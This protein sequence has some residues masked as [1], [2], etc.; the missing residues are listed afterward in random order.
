MW[1]SVLRVDGAADLII[2]EPEHVGPE[3]TGH[4]P[5]V[6]GLLQLYPTITSPQFHVPTFTSKGDPNALQTLQ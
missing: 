4:Y 3:M 2:A 6:F 5:V 1:P